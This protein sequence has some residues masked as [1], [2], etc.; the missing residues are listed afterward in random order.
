SI[1][2]VWC[3]WVSSPRRST[4][5]SA[6]RPRSAPRCPSWWS[7]S[8]TKRVR[9]VFASNDEMP[10][11]R[12]FVIGLSTWLVSPGCGGAD[13]DLPREYRRIE[14]PSGLVTSVESRMRGGRLF[15]EYC[16]LCHGERGDGRGPRREG[17]TQAPRDLTDPSWR[18]STSPRRVFF[19]IREG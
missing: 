3:C 9:W 11:N 13:R 17:L 16:A 15:R 12:L 14:V 1:P 4:S 5:M 19:T 18:A 2:A 7:E 8:P 10:M 6:C